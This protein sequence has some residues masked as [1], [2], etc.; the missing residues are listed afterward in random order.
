MPHVLRLFTSSKAFFEFTVCLRLE[1][2]IRRE[3]VKKFIFVDSQQDTIALCTVEIVLDG[4]SKKIKKVFKNN[5]DLQAEEH[6]LQYLEKEIADLKRKGRQDP[7]DPKNPEGPEVLAVNVEVV[8]N[9]SPS[10]IPRRV[11]EKTEPGFADQIL[12]FKRNITENGIDSSLTITFANFHDHCSKANF[13]GLMR[14]LGSRIELKLLEVD[15][16]IF[17]KNKMFMDLSTKDEDHLGAQANSKE[18]KERE[19]VYIRMMEILDV[20]KGITN[21]N[22]ENLYL[23]IYIFTHAYIHIRL[24]AARQNY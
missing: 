7:E 17:L 12:K 1:K 24:S 11:D 2:R 6:F 15:W 10:N 23:G 18:R 19:N 5:N 4:K 13:E 20:L 9:Y 8:L 22:S 16:G 21:H 14:L 3:D